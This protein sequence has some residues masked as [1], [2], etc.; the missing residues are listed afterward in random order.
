[1]IVDHVRRRLKNEQAGPLR[2]VVLDFSHVGGCDLAAIVAFANIVNIASK[3]GF[4]LLFSGMSGEVRTLFDRS[5]MVFVNAEIV[6]DFVD[7]DH[8][9]E[10]C[11][12][13]MLAEGAFEQ[14]SGAADAL[15]FLSLKVGDHADLPAVLD[16]FRTVHLKSGDYLIRK[17]EEASDVFIVLSGRVHVQ[18]DLPNGRKLRLRTMTPG[19][20]VGDIALYT[21]QRRTADVVIDEDTTVLSL[22]AAALAEIEQSYG[23]LAA[24]IH[25]IFA[26][27][28]AEKLVLANN[29]IRL[30]QR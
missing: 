29:A 14:D 27:T 22:S 7:V 20:I 19:A 15:T 30:A 26:R 24:A 28:L 4:F 9:I 10:F 5:G 8:A 21:G 11:E 6:S 1:M 17:G 23:N 2:F 3:T 18:I 13:A 12:D 16:K 25:R